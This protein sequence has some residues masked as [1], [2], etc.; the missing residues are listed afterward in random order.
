MGVD[1][2]CDSA[3]W[4]RILFK[5]SESPFG[6]FSSYLFFLLLSIIAL[7]SLAIGLFTISVSLIN[8]RI[9]FLTLMIIIF[10][11][12]CHNLVF[13]I[14]IT[15]ATTVLL[16]TGA[17]GP[18]SVNP[19]SLNI[20]SSNALSSSERGLNGGAATGQTKGV[21][22][23]GG[24]HYLFIYSVICICWNWYFVSHFDTE[25]SISTSPIRTHLSTRFLIHL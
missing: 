16:I 6:L 3:D 15:L 23:N 24:R 12:F 14:I 9:I 21:G 13:L 4:L 22:A 25:F 10:T 18:S 1:S 17:Q 11:F 8:L 7:I 19:S 5:H 20:S 2:V